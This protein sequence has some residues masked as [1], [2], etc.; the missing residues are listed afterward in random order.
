MADT[1]GA[2]LST[3]TEE[4]RKREVLEEKRTLI[5]YLNVLSRKS[6]EGARIVSD[7]EKYD[8]INFYE[9]EIISDVLKGHNN[10][11]KECVASD[12]GQKFV[13]N[14]QKRVIKVHLIDILELA[15]KEIGFKFK[16]RTLLNLRPK[17]VLLA[18]EAHTLTCLCDRCANVQE[19][20]KCLVNFIR[21]IRQH[22]SPGDKVALATVVLTTSVSDFISKILHPKAEGQIWH[23]PGC[24]LQTCE[25]TEDNPCG[26]PKLF[27]LLKPLLD[28]FGDREVELHQHVNVPYIKTDGTQSTKFSQV[29]TRQSIKSVAELLDQRVFGHFHQ[30]PYI[31]HRLKMLLGSKLRKDIHENLE[32]TD[33]ACWT[34]YSKELEINEQEA[35]KSAAFGA[36]NVTIQLIGQVYELRVLP[37]TSPTLL[38]YQEGGNNLLFSKPKLD[39]GSNIQCYEIHLKSVNEDTWY[40]LRSVGVQHLSQEPQIPVQLFGRLGGDFLVRVFAR[41]LSGLGA[42]AE[43][44]VKLH[45]DLPFLTQEYDEVSNDQSALKYCTFYAEFF[46]LSD[47]NDSPKVCTLFL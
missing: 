44:A 19:I 2:R 13:I 33:A 31:Q 29:L 36:S 10:V 3:V 14:R 21:N 18:N 35:C 25:S 32:L 43:I 8:V 40:L 38:S 27:L 30:Q 47:H 41:N 5:P 24:Y 26:S 1:I 6:P 12:S 15:Q 46:F 11:F 9:S 16:L 4:A 23:R 7:D 34:D 39:G 28:R 20:L 42:F 37:P 17:W 22:G 45:G